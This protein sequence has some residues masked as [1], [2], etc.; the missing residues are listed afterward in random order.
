MSK[1]AFVFPGQGSQYVGMG[2]DFYESFSE[3]K[4]V[5]ERASELLK[6]DMRKLCHEE[7]DE[8]NITEFT[9][10]AMITTMGAMLRH[11]N[12]I[13]IKPSVCAGLSLGEYAALIASEALELEDAISLVRKR[14]IL[15]QEAVPKGK[16]SMS[17]VLSLDANIVEEVCESMDGTVCI[18]NYN[19]PGQV[20]ISGEKAAVEEAGEQ[21]LHA[22]AKRVIPLNV[23]GPFHSPLLKDAGDKLYSELIN[24]SFSKPK[25]PYIANVNATKVVTQ[26]RIPELLA[27][28]VYSSVRWEQSVRNM[29]DEGVD[30]FIEIGPG[31]TLSSFIKKIDRN[32]NVI[33]VETIKDLEKLNAFK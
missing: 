32:Q 21:L 31:K 18:A 8:I 4:E 26:E 5:Y 25:A 14:G 15:M 22:G 23:S 16:G 9:Q 17:A 2:K 10:A 12:T 20:V 24:I 29:I 27:M 13:E 33:N 19:C 28:Q 30:T 11:I 6:L 3:S 7:N 1:I